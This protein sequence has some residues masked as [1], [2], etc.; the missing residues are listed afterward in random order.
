MTEELVVL[1]PEW[2][3]DRGSFVMTR[4]PKA[5]GKAEEAAG[6]YMQLWRLEPDGSWKVAYDI[7]NSDRPYAG[8][9]Q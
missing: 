9:T 1:S 3:M 5:G 6:T 2:V 4:T 8:G 7:W